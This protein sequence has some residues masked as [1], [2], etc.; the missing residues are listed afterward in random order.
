M[1]IANDRFQWIER[2]VKLWNLTDVETMDL[3]VAQEQFA[4]ARAVLNE[5]LAAA[6]QDNRSLWTWLRDKVRRR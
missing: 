3:P 6:H 2:Q 4:E 1:P 5:I